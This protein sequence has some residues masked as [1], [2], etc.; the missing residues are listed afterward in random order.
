MYRDGLVF[1]LRRV[2]LRLATDVPAELS[3]PRSK[4]RFQYHLHLAPA[5]SRGGRVLVLDKG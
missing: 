2:D 4:K 5:T 3:S 1:L